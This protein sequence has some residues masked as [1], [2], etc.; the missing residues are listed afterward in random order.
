MQ[1]RAAAR[2]VDWE[3]DPLA[4]DDRLALPHSVTELRM[5]VAEPAH[6]E[7]LARLECDRVHEAAAVDEDVLEVAC[8][9]RARPPFEAVVD[10]SHHLRGTAVDASNGA[11]LV[12]SAAIAVVVGVEVSGQR[13]EVDRCPQPEE[14]RL[15]DWRTRGRELTDRADAPR[16]IARPPHSLGGDVVAV[17]VDFYPAAPCAELREPRVV[18]ERANARPPRVVRLLDRGG[19]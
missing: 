19:P 14:L 7:L 9:A 17:A 15:G 6:Q 4:A 1:V 10:R 2:V 16:A 5:S 18:E 11:D 8:P 3:R 12:P 13:R